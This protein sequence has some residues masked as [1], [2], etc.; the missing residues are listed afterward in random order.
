MF[1]LYIGQNV[2]LEHFCLVRLDLGK[3]KEAHIHCFYYDE[4]SDRYPIGIIHRGFLYRVSFNEIGHKP[5]PNKE[6]LNGLIDE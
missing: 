5:N 4:D 2:I 6:L 1:G 3:T